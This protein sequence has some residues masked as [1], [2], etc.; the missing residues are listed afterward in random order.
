MK[1]ETG[2]RFCKEGVGALTSAAV[3]AAPCTPRLLPPSN[4]PGQA[5]HNTRAAA[6][7]I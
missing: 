3:V 2:P 7:D 5:D 4:L 6:R 1:S